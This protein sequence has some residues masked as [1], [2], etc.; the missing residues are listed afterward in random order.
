M[1]DRRERIST[2][3]LRVWEPSKREDG[4]EVWRLTEVKECPSCRGNLELDDRFGFVTCPSC[5][6]TAR[7]AESHRLAIAVERLRSA[8]ERL[9]SASFLILG[10]PVVLG[11]LQAAFRLVEWLAEDVERLSTLKEEDEL[12][13]L[14]EDG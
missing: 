14:S 9:R 5:G 13:S 8:A 1:R 6:W 4:R 2:S 7:L 3:P 10:E 12:S 11:R